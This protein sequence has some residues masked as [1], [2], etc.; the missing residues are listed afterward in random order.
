M[1]SLVKAMRRMAHTVVPNGVS[2]EA[3][4]KLVRSIYERLIYD[5]GTQTVTVMSG[6][7]KGMKKHGPFRESDFD[8]ALGQY[9]RET[10][11]ALYQFCRPGMTVF[12]IGAN[13]GYLTLLM[14]KLVGASGHVYAFEPIPQNCQ[15]LSET[16]RINGL[17]NVAVHQVAV[18]DQVGKAQ[19]NYV[20]I[21]DGFAALI[22]GGH[23]YYRGQSVNTVSVTTTTLDHFCNDMRIAEIGLIKM[24]IEGAEMLALAGM[25]RI[26][27]VQQPVVIIEFWG[28]EN[29]I[30][31]TRLLKSQGYSVKT[32][33]AWNGFVRGVKA[34]IQNILALPV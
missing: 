3:Y 25:S 14:A 5:P 26:L 30:E 13:A 8:F 24:D 9:E 15:Y 19:M 2:P 6:P 29:I 33:S 23:D 12:D 28:A 10:V 11:D 17:R 20:G 22:N 16:L 4:R 7:L 18:S 34:D 1:N 31:G 32:L 27:A 21:F